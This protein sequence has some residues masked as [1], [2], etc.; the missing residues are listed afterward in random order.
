M[1]YDKSRNRPMTYAWRI[2]SRILETMGRKCEALGS[3]MSYY[4]KHR[5]LKLVERSD[6]VLCDG[7]RYFQ[8]G[9]FSMTIGK[10]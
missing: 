5:T 6:Y 1:H 7:V 10:L 3:L 4:S 8:N 9:K 2:S